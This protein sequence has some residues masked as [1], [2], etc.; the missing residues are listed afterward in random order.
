MY[1]TE[2]V[3]RKEEYASKTSLQMFMFYFGLIKL[4]RNFEKRKSFIVIAV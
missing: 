4:L 2:E 3:T 1:V